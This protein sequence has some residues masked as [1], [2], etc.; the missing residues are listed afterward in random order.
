MKF[1]DD[2]RLYGQN[3]HN[4]ELG[5]VIHWH[6][7]VATLEGMSEEVPHVMPYDNVLDVI[8]V[9]PRHHRRS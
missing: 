4:G 9:S 8:L 5:Q 6:H 7:D 2:D 1:D 3:L